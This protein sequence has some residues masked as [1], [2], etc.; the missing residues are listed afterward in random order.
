MQILAHRLNYPMRS[1]L[2][3]FGSALQSE[4]LFDV[5]LIGFNCF[6]TQVQFSR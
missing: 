4:F 5:R 1:L 6:D 3:Q 2:A